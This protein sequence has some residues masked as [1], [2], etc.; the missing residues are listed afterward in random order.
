MTIEE[1]ILNS[2]QQRD[3]RQAERDRKQ[4]EE[5]RRIETLR[6]EVL[7]Q[8]KERVGALIPEPLREF[9]AYAGPQPDEDLLK[10]FPRRWQPTEFVIDAP[11]HLAPINFTITNLSKVVSISVAGE[12]F[13]DFIEAVAKAADLHDQPPERKPGL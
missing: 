12:T 8:I 3:E 9:V 7:A 13:P 6:A 10:G 1:Y 2:K 11:E 5:R 4:D